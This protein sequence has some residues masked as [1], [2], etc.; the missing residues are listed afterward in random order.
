MR[1]AIALLLGCLAGASLVVPAASAPLS[2]DSQKIYDTKVKPFLAAHCIKCHNDKKASAAFQIDHLSTDFLSGKTAG[3]T[4]DHWKEMMDNINLGKMPPKKEARPNPKEAFAVVEWIAQELRN[5]EARAKNSSGRIPT[6]RLNRTEY[7]KTLSHLFHFDED[8]ATGLM[9]DL[10]ADG[11]EGGFDRGGKSLVFDEQLLGKYVDLADLVLDRHVFAP[12]PKTVRKKYLTRDIRWHNAKD[13]NKFSTV[14][15]YPFDSHRTGTVRLPLGPTYCEVK[16]GG[17]EFIAGWSPQCRLEC[18]G[19]QWFSPWSEPLLA[20]GLQ[21]GWYHIKIRAGAFKGSGA[22]AVDQVK[23]LFRY[24]P[25]TPIATQET[26]VIDAPLDKPREFTAKVYLRSG[27][28][29]IPKQYQLSWNGTKDIL[30]RNPVTEKLEREHYNMLTRYN[31]LALAK[32]PAAELAAEKKKR[33]EL[34]EKFHQLVTESK[35][36]QFIYNPEID[37]KTIP[38]LFLESVEIEGPIVPWPPKAHTE[39]FFDGKTRK[40]DR[41]YLREIFVRFLPRAYRRPVEPKEV[42]DLVAWALKTQAKYGLSGI[43]TVREGIKYVLCSPG[44][45]LLEESAGPADKPR[46]ITDYELASR[47][48]YF[49]WSTMPDAELFTLA[50]KNKLHEPTTLTAQVRR[51]L[52]DPKA[53]GLIRN[54]TG[55]WLKV[56][57]FDNVL[58][59]RRLFKTYDDQLRESSRQEPYEFFQEVLTKN[60]SILNFVDSDFLVI[61]ERLARHYGIEGVKGDAFRRVAIR[62]EHR[63]GGVLGMAGVLTYLS[64]GLRTLPVRRAAFVLESLWNAPPPPPPPDVSNLPVVKGKN[65]TVRARLDLHRTEPMCASCHTRV[66]PFGMALENYD[67]IGAWRDR[68]RPDTKTPVLDVS[69]VLPSGRK[70]KDLPSYK[71]ALLA[72]KERFVHAFTEKMLTYALGRPVGVTDRETTEAI[73]KATE[74]DDYRM[75]SLIQGVVSSQAFQTK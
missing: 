69:G 57:E 19:G 30:V 44:F 64:D 71:K 61:D 6:R 52:A 36:A 48:S 38:R 43:E 67:A 1:N 40:I 45:L 28:P 7:V 29:E 73:I 75:Q 37:L 56:R 60:L 51:M 5:A 17:F 68:E 74:R 54:F 50:A 21:D 27:S 4:A 15:S 9:D 63:R 35:P 53:Q 39:I 12:K 65:L 34:C 47:L 23:I 13:Q 10:P 66:D 46:Q 18:A 49:L 11:T 62:P 55:Q 33:E 16:N 41:T 58:T 70:F 20:A 31:S 72:E 24:A 3:K 42:D 32:R 14:N 8:A 25:N 22:R 26:I 2:P 59:D